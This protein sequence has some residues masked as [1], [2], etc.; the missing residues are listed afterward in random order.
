MGGGADCP[1]PTKVA[2]LATSKIR[3]NWRRRIII[4]HLTKV[5]MAKSSDGLADAEWNQ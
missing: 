5:G 4:T 1:Q 2:E 3:L